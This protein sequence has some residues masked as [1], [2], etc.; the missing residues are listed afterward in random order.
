M[1]ENGYSCTGNHGELSVCSLSCGNGIY[2]PGSS[3]MCDD[4]N[5]D[6]GDGCDP[7]CFTEMNWECSPTSPSVCTP[8]C[9]DGF[10]VPPYEECDDASNVDGDGCASDCIVESGWSCTGEPSVCE[11][12]SPCSNQ[13]VEP[14]ENEQCDDGNMASGDGCSSTC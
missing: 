8:I 6:G 1:I 11:V 9:G 12:V 13:F 7:M 14:L 4:G 2:E 10:F 5:T 3:E